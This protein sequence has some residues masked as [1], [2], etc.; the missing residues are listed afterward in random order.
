MG[1]VPPGLRPGSYFRTDI[2]TGHIFM[3]LTL[4][5]KT[6]YFLTMNV[7]NVQLIHVSDLVSV[8]I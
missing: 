2:E 8:N 1:W 7:I 3:S 4:L 5:G 6:D